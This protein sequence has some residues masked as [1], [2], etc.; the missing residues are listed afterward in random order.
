MLESGS[1][2]LGAIDFQRQPDRYEP[3]MDIYGLS[4]TEAR[5]IIDS[6]VDSIHTHWSAAADAGRLS[7]AD[8]TRLWGRQI[9]NPYTFRDYTS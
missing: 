7:E 6:I 5:E 2:R 4:T 3:R 9:Q 1:N 8:R